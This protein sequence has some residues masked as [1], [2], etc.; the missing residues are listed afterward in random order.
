MFSYNYLGSKFLIPQLND[1]YFHI[2]QS[3]MDF[4]TT[5]TEDPDHFS[6]KD[7]NNEDEPLDAD[8]I[9]QAVL[10]LCENSFELRQESIQF[11]CR[12]LENENTATREKIL[13]LLKGNKEYIVS[14]L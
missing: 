1:I 14:A 5:K 11:I 3:L 12:A 6:E 8:L 9:T 2:K 10:N 13:L 7:I 4:T